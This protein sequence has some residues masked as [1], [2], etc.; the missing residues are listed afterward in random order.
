M[1]PTTFSE[2]ST[3]WIKYIVEHVYKVYIDRIET[4]TEDAFKHVD[5]ILYAQSLVNPELAIM[6]SMYN[7]MTN[8]FSFLLAMHNW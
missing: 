2:Q 6:A 4:H 1:Y 5:E 3:L 8:W 7:I